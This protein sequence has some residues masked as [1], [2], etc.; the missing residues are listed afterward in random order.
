MIL[1]YSIID[2]NLAW[3]IPTRLAFFP[4][5]IAIVSLLHWLCDSRETITIAIFATEWNA[6]HKN[7]K[8]VLLKRSNF[9]RLILGD[10]RYGMV[11]WLY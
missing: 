1:G 3:I 11:N 2:Q 8:S 7:D 9:D 4:K 5:S 10:L 6:E